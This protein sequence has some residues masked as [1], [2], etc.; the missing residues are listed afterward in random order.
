[1]SATPHTPRPPRQRSHPRP[2]ALAALVG[3]WLVPTA[4]WSQDPVN[5]SPTVDASPGAEAPEV[6]RVGTLRVGANQPGAK[7]WV[8]NVEV[9]VAPL[10]RRL[11]PGEHTV[12]V[13]ADNFN[14]FVATVDVVEDKTAV[15]QA[16]LFPGGGTVEFAINAPGGTVVIDGTT[17]SKLPVRLPRVAAGSYRYELSAP[18]YESQTG[19]FTFESGDNLYIYAELPRSAG[20]FVVDTTPMATDI[21]LDGKPLGAGPIRR[22]NLAP[23]PHLLEVTAPGRAT[24]LRAADTSDGSKLSIT[25]PI[26]EKGGTTKLRTGKSGAVVTMSGVTIGE[27][28]SVVLDDVARGR[29]PIEVSAPGYRTAQGRL[30]VDAGTRATYKVDWEREAARSRSQ[31]VEMPPWY[32]RWT[33]WTIAG[34][35]VAIG[36]TTAVLLIRANQ[37]EPIPDG[38]ITVSLP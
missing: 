35:T 10:V 1:M 20:L 16:Q 25:G 2:G 24:V 38:D 19:T 15:V 11:A 14:P 13:A 12:R 18:G 6:L 29:Y 27:G 28:R 4:S 33:T 7:V 32:S 31:V 23:G 34:G 17:E 36:V 9:G 3:A 22:D 26:P 21:V 37:P 8:D 5:A 30:A